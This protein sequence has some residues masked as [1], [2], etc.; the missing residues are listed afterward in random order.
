MIAVIQADKAD[1]PVQFEEDG[2]WI[3]CGDLD[4]PLFNFGECKYRVKPKKPYIAR[5]IKWDSDRLMDDDAPPGRYV[6]LTDEVKA[7]LGDMVDE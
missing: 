7:L 1:K 6:E 2:V 5:I 3:D 4:P